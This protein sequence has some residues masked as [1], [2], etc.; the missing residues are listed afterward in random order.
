M[1]VGLSIRNLFVLTLIGSFA[2]TVYPL[3]LNAESKNVAS[4]QANPS[5]A[6]AASPFAPPNNAAHPFWHPR[7]KKINQNRRHRRSPKQVKQV[8]QIMIRQL[9]QTFQKHIYKL[10]KEP[11]T[12]IPRYN[13]LPRNPRPA[14]R[15]NTTEENYKMFYEQLQQYA[16]ILHVLNQTEPPA[17]YDPNQFSHTERQTIINSIANLIK[18]M[19]CELEFTMKGKTAI[20]PVDKGEIEKAI[21]TNLNHTQ[22]YVYDMATYNS[23][24][25]FLVSWKRVLQ[26][27]RKNGRKNANKKN[28]K[29]NKKKNQ[30]AEKKKK[31]PKDAKLGKRKSKKVK[32][33]PQ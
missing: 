4:P 32:A 23:Y 3:P 15:Q 27:G 16:V 31:G 25:K 8:L 30:K 22:L 2:Y 13:W 10:Y 20:K 29:N 19:L 9:N 33:K 5:A 6:A 12:K 18:Q 21:P 17:G 26:K 24:K 7:C 11:M 28:N 1:A 14:M